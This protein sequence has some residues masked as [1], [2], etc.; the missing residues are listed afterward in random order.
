MTITHLE[1]IKRVND[2]FD[3]GIDRL[4]I[5]IEDESDIRE[6]DKWII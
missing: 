4:R 6:L 2:Y 5:N 3:I 1:K